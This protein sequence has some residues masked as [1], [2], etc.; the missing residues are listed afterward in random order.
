MDNAHSF[1]ADSAT[2]A[3]AAV[4]AIITDIGTVDLSWARAQFV[5]VAHH[6]GLNQHAFDEMKLT[7][8]AA[9]FRLKSEGDER[10]P[11]AAVAGTVTIILIHDFLDFATVMISTAAIDA[12]GCCFETHPS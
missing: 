7:N 3:F 2:K 11:Y 1:I 6:D 10:V 12:I 5:F 9:S 4:A 8:V